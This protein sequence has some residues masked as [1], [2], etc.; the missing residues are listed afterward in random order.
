MADIS[1]SEYAAV[2]A[3]LEAGCLQRGLASIK[4]YD[5]EAVMITAQKLE[6]LAAEARKNGQDRVLI[7]IQTG[8]IMK[9]EVA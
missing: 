1:K 9:G 4:F 3:E 8:P 6:E 5:G 2:I 7:F